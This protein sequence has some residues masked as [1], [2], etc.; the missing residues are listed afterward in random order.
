MSRRL[1]AFTLVELLVVV[2][3]ISLLIAI[4]MPT[5]SRAMDLARSLRCEA[6]LQQIGV[7]TANY[8]N[9]SKGYVFPCSYSSNATL[10]ATGSGLITILAPYIPNQDQTTTIWTCPA[11]VIGNTTQFLLTY[12][13]NTG[14]HPNYNYDAS[15]VPV[16]GKDASGSSY[17]NLRKITMLPRQYELVTIADGSQSSGAWT[18]GQ[19][20]DWTGTDTNEMHTYSLAN[21]PI[22][23]TGGLSGWNNTDVGNYHVRYRH[24]ANNNGNC[25]FL[26][27]HVE[28]VRYRALLMRNFAT[29]Y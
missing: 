27:G 14:V 23:G 7:A 18:A 5:L 25:L 3:I 24:L 2:A 9:D 16:V 1:K 22:S 29:G 12:S 10:G 6:Q 26:D 21:N 17:R 15:N 11:A 20:F 28:S 8:L 19:A 4:L 13:C